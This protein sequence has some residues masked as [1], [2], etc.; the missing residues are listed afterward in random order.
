MRRIFQRLFD[1]ITLIQQGTQ[2]VD[3]GEEK[4]I[5]ATKVFLAVKQRRVQV[6][7]ISDLKK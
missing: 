6:V 5:T 2:E 7:M 3:L 4:T 1:P